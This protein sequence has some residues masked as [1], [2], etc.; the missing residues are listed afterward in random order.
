MEWVSSNVL[1]P[2]IK[3]SIPGTVYVPIPRIQFGLRIECKAF[4]TA[5]RGNPLNVVIQ[6]KPNRYHLF[7]LDLSE[8]RY[9]HDMSKAITLLYSSYRASFWKPCSLRRIVGVEYVKVLVLR[10]ERLLPNS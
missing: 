2:E 8:A 1:F 5:P 3:Q 7:K 6:W 10:V 9:Q 4:D